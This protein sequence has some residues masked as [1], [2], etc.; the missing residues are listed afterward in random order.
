VAPSRCRSSTCCRA[1]GTGP[2]IKQR[3]IALGLKEYRCESCGIDEWRERPLSLAL[4]HVNGVGTD[5]P[6]FISGPVVIDAKPAGSRVGD[7]SSTGEGR[8]RPIAARRSA[9]GGQGVVD[10]ER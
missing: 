8:D 2:H 9:L 4:H 7:M 5:N 1:R 3:L 10:V 6:L